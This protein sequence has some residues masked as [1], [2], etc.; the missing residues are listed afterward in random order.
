MEQPDRPLTMGQVGAR[1]GLP[2]WKIRRVFEL[3]IL[4]EPA[5]IGA[6]RVVYEADLPAIEAALKQ[7]RCLQPVAAKA[8]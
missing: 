8:S 1:F 7:T 5:R 4:P 3:G 6:Y 2:A